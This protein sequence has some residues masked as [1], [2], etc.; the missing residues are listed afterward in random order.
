MDRGETDGV[1]RIGLVAAVLGVAVADP[2][3]PAEAAASTRHE[4][5]PRDD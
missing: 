3:A 2:D 5:S 1:A 4:K